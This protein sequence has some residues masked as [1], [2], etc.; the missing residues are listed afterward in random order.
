MTSFDPTQTLRGENLHIRKLKE[1]D[2]DALFAAMSDPVI[3][4]GHPKKD[5]YKTDEINSWFEIAL[6]E[7]ALAIININN[8]ELIGSSRYYE[9]NLEFREVAIGYTFLIVKHWGGT[10]NKELKSLMLNH[11]W[12]YFD[13]VWLHIGKDNVRSRKAAEKIGA[14]F[15]HLGELDSIPYCWY[16]IKEA[17][18]NAA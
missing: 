9:I 18:F 7:N 13:T 17:D 4:Q 11:A 6:Q 10:T 14:R 12:E 1:D 15:D 2:F 5:R 16:S 8:N 3:W